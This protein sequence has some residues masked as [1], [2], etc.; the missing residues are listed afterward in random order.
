MFDYPIS[1]SVSHIYLSALPY[2]PSESS[3]LQHWSQEY[4]NT[5]RVEAGRLE[6]WSAILRVLHAG[7]AVTSVVFSPDGTRIASG[8][9]D[10][11][12][13]L[14][15]AASGTAIG[16]PLQGHSHFV[17]S[18]AFSPDGT[19][20][21]S[22]SH[23]NTIRLWDA[24][25]GT[26]ISYL[27]RHPFPV[28]PNDNN[29]CIASNAEDTTAQLGHA[30]ISSDFNP[31]PGSSESSPNKYG[32]I[33]TSRNPDIAETSTFSNCSPLGDDG[34]VTLPGEKLLFWVPP[35][36][37]LGLLRPGTLKV[38]GAPETRIDV[39][40]FA[41]GTDWTRCRR[42]LEFPAFP[43]VT[44]VFVSISFQSINRILVSG[45]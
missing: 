27:L 39:M 2:S 12:I 9:G 18:V 16:E 24:T 21:A 26:A 36:N 34:W 33:I 31:F 20:I 29:V 7:S 32:A 44:G 35:A 43:T 13:R 17:R 14:W 28:T 19:C 5:L 4:P 11:T 37:R 30:S 42:T 1:Q 41:H 8:S 38:F 15:D 6:K 45:P 23:D 3:L 22:G 40:N 10:D 25:S